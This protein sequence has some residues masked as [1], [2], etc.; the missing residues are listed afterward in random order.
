[1]KKTLAIIVLVITF[2]IIYF[3]QANFFTW[4]NIGGVMPNLF[5]IF[6]LFIGL[7]VGKK[8]GV[9]LGIIFGVYLDIVIGNSIF[10]TGALLGLIGLISEFLEKNFS[11]DSRITIILIISAGTALFEVFFYIFKIIA[12]VAHFEFLQFIKILAI[13]II[14]NI[15]ITII[16]YPLIQKTGNILEKLFKNVTLRYF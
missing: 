9:I 2:F 8:V 11:K 1:M 12:T 7:F 16:L 4:F 5:V 3:L 15:L 13:E 10:I 6:V 14:F